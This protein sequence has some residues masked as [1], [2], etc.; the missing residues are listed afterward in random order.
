M[1]NTVFEPLEEQRHQ[2]ITRMAVVIQKTWRGHIQ[3]KGL[4]HKSG[5][6]SKYLERLTLLTY[7]AEYTRKRQA[8]ITIQHRYRGIR[9]RLQFLRMRRAA[10]VLQVLVFT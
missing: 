6:L 3:K 9:L 5:N 1:R 2:L 10:I 8:A 7:F 4:C